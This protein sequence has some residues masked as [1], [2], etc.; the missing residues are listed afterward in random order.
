MGLNEILL[1][2]PIVMTA[3]L[4][5][6]HSS[7]RTIANIVYDS[8]TS[9]EPEPFSIAVFGQVN[10]RKSIA[11][12]KVI[13]TIL[14]TLMGNPSSWNSISQFQNVKVYNMN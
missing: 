13:Q 14:H 5:E 4:G 1:R 8:L 7:F 11:V 9:T 3:D 12:K 2:F 6:T 10:S